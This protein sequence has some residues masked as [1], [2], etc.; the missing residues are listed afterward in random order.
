MLGSEEHGCA[1]AGCGGLYEQLLGVQ[2][3]VLV[4]APQPGQ[5]LSLD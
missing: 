5:D 3:L 1:A 4:T 2:G